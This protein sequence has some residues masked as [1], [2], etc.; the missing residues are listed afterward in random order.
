MRFVNSETGKALRLR[1]FNAR[2]VES[3]PVRPGDVVRVVR[4]GGLDDQSEH[5]LRRSSSAV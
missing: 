3:G 2:V 4:R 1:G 5:R